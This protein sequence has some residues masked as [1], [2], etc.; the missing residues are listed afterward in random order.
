MSSWS[1]I[2]ALIRV[3]AY[4]DTLPFHDM[5]R[6][7]LHHAPKIYGSEG[8]ATVKVIDWGLDN[9]TCE[10][11][12]GGSCHTNVP[13]VT[14]P[15]VQYCT[16]AAK[17]TICKQARVFAKK[18]REMSERGEEYN[19]FYGSVALVRHC[20]VYIHGGLRDTNPDQT[21]A[22]FKRL[23]QYIKNSFPESGCP[24]EARVVFSK[25]N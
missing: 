2:T 12:L 5:V 18:H 8:N 20:M 6:T 17:S 10:G 19:G 3:S 15:S 9:V 14:C 23:V 11:F 21:K 16:L 22:E 24:L 1:Y 13:C 7:V 4:G 25:I